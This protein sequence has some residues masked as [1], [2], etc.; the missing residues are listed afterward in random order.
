MKEIK[1]FENFEHNDDEGYEYSLLRE[2]DK[3]ESYI[4][5]R[6]HYT[7]EIRNIL[8]DNDGRFTMTNQLAGNI[9]MD[10]TEMIKKL[11]YEIIK[12]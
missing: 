3:S 7:E 5:F 12:K 10:I 1:K 6:K 2:I 9:I 4:D 8:S 11:G